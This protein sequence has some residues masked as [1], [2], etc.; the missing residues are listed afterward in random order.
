M[1]KLEIVR[2]LLINHEKGKEILSQTVIELI[3]YIDPIIVKEYVWMY[4]LGDS[5]KLSPT[6]ILTGLL[7]QI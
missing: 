7:S 5:E 6:N 4:L 3:K 1:E 2:E